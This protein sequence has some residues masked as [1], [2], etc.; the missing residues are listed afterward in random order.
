MSRY[1]DSTSQPMRVVCEHG[2]SEQI[3]REMV[4]YAITQGGGGVTVVMATTHPEV[5]WKTV[6]RRLLGRDAIAHMD[7]DQRSITL[8]NGTK[9]RIL[10]AETSHV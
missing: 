3:A 4:E 7:S 8:K 9:L 6:L 1:A 5:A 2:K 10:T